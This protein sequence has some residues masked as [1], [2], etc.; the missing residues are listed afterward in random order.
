MKQHVAVVRAPN[1]SL[2]SG[3]GPRLLS[4]GQPDEVLDGLRRVFVEKLDDEIPLR[5]REVRV[6]ARAIF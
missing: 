5:R 2:R 4:L 1:L 6:N 3:V